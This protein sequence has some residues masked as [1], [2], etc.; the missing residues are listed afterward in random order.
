MSAT[1]MRVLMAV[2]S[3]QTNT[4]PMALAWA[5]EAGVRAETA[6]SLRDS[7]ESGRRSQNSSSP[8]ISVIV[9]V[10]VLVVVGVLMVE[11]LT[12]TAPETTAPTLRPCGI[13]SGTNVHTQIQAITGLTLELCLLLSTTSVSYSRPKGRHRSHR[14]YERNKRAK[15]GCA[16]I[17]KQNAVFPF[18]SRKI[19]GEYSRISQL[20]DSESQH[21]CRSPVGQPGRF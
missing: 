13:E 6:P 19:S 14:E 1:P 7:S 20:S 3:G 21:L 4:R 18:A 5:A 8:F 11:L 16:D 2:Y 10:A 15:G 12:Q 9:I 17:S